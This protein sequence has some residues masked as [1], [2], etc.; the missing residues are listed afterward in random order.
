VWL[1]SLGLGMARYGK[2]G[3]PMAHLNQ[4]ECGV[5]QY[6]G[7]RLG[8]VRFGQVRCSRAW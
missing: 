7:A 6:G 4:E 1:G 8:S 2:V 3:V 5:V